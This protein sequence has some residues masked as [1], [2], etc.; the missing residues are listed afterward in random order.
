MVC[1]TYL[2]RGVAF[3]SW[4]P[5]FGSSLGSHCCRLSW[6]DWPRWPKSGR[7]LKRRNSV[8]ILR[9]PMRLHHAMFDEPPIKRAARQHPRIEQA[10][11]M[12]PRKR[13]NAHQ[14]PVGFQAVLRNCAENESKCFG[15]GWVLIRPPQAQSHRLPPRRWFLRLWS[16]SRRQRPSGS[17]RH[18]NHPKHPAPDQPNRVRPRPAGRDRTHAS[19]FLNG[20]RSPI[21]SA[22]RTRSRGVPT[23]NLRRRPSRRCHHREWRDRPVR[24]RVQTVGRRLPWPVGS[25]TEGVFSKQS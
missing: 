18:L 2:P 5:P 9:R 13:T 8:A 11:A 17:A 14:P 3:S 19:Q 22:A 1:S 6:A 4:V 23:S 20:V 7:R 15:V 10:A 24:I 12:L 21:A 16:P 25:E